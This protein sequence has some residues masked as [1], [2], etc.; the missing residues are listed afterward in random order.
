MPPIQTPE[1]YGGS[2]IRRRSDSFYCCWY[3][4]TVRTAYFPHEEAATGFAE[5]LGPQPWTC[6]SV[7]PLAGLPW[8]KEQAA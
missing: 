2:R 4:G 7:M 8:P 5:S 6:A 1:F 3:D